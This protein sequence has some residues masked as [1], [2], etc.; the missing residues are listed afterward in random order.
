MYQNYVVEVKKNAQGE[1]DHQVY[2]LYDE[3]ADTAM[4]KAKSKYLQQDL[5]LNY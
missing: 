1:F 5:N 3:N 4:L 2:W